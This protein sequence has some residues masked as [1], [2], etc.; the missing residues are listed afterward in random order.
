MF[1]TLTYAKK[2]EDA[3][4]PRLQAEAQVQVLAEIVEGELATKSDIQRDLKELEYRLILKLSAI[5]GT[6]T[7]ILG[8]VVTFF[9]P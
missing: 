2:L 6:M 5:V 8:V 7:S 4:V 1:N 9:R 3:G